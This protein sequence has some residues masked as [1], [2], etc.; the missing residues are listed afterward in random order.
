MDEKISKDRG[1]ERATISL[2]DRYGDKNIEYIQV[3][4]DYFLSDI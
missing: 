1:R 3:K 4:T 2:S